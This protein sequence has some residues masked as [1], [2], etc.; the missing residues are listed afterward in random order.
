MDERNKLIKS[1]YHLIGIGGIGMAAIA[2]LLLDKGC[3]ISGSDVA[4]NYVI[5]NLIKKGAEVFIGHDENN[6][7]ESDIV[8]FS[9]AIKD[10]NCELVCARNKGKK[11][12]RRAEVLALLM[13]D[14]VSITVA[15]AHGKTTTS[16]L[17]STI[18]EKANLHPT[19]AIGGI[20]Q[21]NANTSKVGDGK[22]F[23]SE[24]DE[25][26]GS[27]LLFHSD[28]SIITNID[29]EHIEHYGTFEKLIESYGEFI[30]NVKDNGILIICKED[31]ILLSLAKES[32]KNFETYGFNDSCDLY[33]S[34]IV[35]RNSI[36]LN[37]EHCTSFDVHYKGKFVDRFKTNLLGRFNVLNVLAS[38]LLS[39]KLGIGLSFIKEALMEFQGVKRRFQIKFNNDNLTIVDD[40][41]HHPTEIKNT[42]DAADL[43]K[44]N[45]LLVVVQPHRY[46]RVQSLMQE[47]AEALVKCDHLVITD[48]YAAS[49]KPVEGITSQKLVEEVNKISKN[50]AEYVP[51]H[52]VN[53][54]LLNIVKDGDLLLFLGAGDITKIS[55]EFV[56]SLEEN[57]INK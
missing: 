20:I 4:D 54:H 33:A 31:E 25:S 37:S 3:K 8:I 38:I 47:F 50:Y 44:K 18:L 14:Y 2:N 29:K 21:G 12:Y 24:L 42:L 56:N 43:V 27:F 57:I 7:G 52:L 49:E 46:S 51:K 53:E 11:I 9:S 55:E 19:S 45:R 17:V 35:L 13:Q 23:V 6:V 48:I 39:L 5:E 22:F 26:D 30:T 16:S 28:Y 15:G 36:E 10:D 41:A 34:N 32:S 1:K 40:Y